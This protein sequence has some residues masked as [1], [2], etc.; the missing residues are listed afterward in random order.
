MIYQEI[1]SGLSI[2]SDKVSGHHA[3]CHLTRSVI[4][5]QVLA[6]GV[7]YTG[8]VGITCSGGEPFLP[9]VSAQQVVL[10]MAGNNNCVLGENM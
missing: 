2:V 5:D 7:L 8:L 9:V 3:Q 1:N 6:S 4:A 10:V